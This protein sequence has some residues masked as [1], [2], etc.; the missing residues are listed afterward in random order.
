MTRLLTAQDVAQLI[1]HVGLAAF[2]QQLTLTMDNDFKRWNEFELN[3]RQAVHYPHGVIE[4][5]PIADNQLFSFKYVNGHP[6]NPQHNKLTVMATGQLS[7]TLTGYPALLCDMTLAT[8]LRTA[9]TSALAAQYLANKN[10]STM[11]IIG[12]GAQSE[13]Q[14]LAL[15]Y[16]TGATHIRFYD[17]D[18][19]AM[20]KFQSNL[21]PYKL[22]L[23]PC[24]TATEALQNAEIITTATAAKL[25]TDV[26][27]NSP[28]KPGTF[29]NA[30]GGDCPGKTELNPT[31]LQ[32]HTV[33]VELLEQSL[34]E[35]DIQH[36]D[37]H[38]QVIELWK[39]IAGQ[40]PGRNTAEETIIFDSVG[41]AIEDFS[42]MK[43]L[44]TLANQHNIGKEIEIIPSLEDHKNLFAFMESQTTAQPSF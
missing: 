40:H 36:L 25:H 39:I 10:P 38:S 15:H 8:A 17:T 9:A 7:D 35:G 13:F 12:T 18:P 2:F 24:N 28:I 26:L 5:M 11:A 6:N 21:Q 34:I 31:F 27:D 32:K 23:Q 22:Q 19:Q 42:T 1:Q 20:K 43:V 3:P 4:L 29:I 14:I 44:L 33:V 37:D 30:I 41:C 16:L